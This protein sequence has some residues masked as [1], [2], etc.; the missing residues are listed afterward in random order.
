MS[1]VR[2][3]PDVPVVHRM[4]TQQ[5]V[6]AWFA[7]N[8][9]L[10]GGLLLLASTIFRFTL[11]FEG[12]SDFADNLKFFADLCITGGA[13]LAVAGRTNSDEVHEERVHAEIRRRSG[14]YPAYRRRVTDV[15][16]LASIRKRDQGGSS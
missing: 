6:K 12:H 1:V 16:Q 14:E 3:L 9:T 15:D 4:P 7:M 8:R 13:A 5:K 2:R 11:H 10:V